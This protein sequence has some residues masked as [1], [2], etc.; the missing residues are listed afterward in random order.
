LPPPPAGPSMPSAG[1]VAQQSAS[2]AIASKLGGFGL[3]GLGKKK[4][5]DPPPADPDSAATAAQPTSS[6]LLETR[7]QMG[8]FSRTANEANFAIPAGFK[9]VQ[10]KGE[11]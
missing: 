3:G 1:D 11:N 10:M 7:T 6:V 8:D 4:K 2:S 9:L 5:V